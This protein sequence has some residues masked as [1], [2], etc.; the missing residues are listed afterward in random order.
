MKKCNHWRYKRIYNHGKKGK[1]ILKC[2]DC[3]R[4]IHKKDL[5]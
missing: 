3:K 2:K 5:K 4:I 1:S